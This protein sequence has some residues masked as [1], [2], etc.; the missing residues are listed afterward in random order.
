MGSVEL[1]EQDRAANMAEEAVRVTLEAMVQPT[2]Q[3]SQVTV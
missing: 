1:A 2:E 3:M